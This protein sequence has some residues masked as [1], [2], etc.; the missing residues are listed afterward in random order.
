M[1]RPHR[2]EFTDNAFEALR[3]PAALEADEEEDRLPDILSSLQ[4]EVQYVLD[5]IYIGRTS[6]DYGKTIKQNCANRFARI[7]S[8]ACCRSS[9]LPKGT[10]C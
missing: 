2:F 7:C 1:I 8:I 5:T 6:R 3:S 4:V 10:S 9:N